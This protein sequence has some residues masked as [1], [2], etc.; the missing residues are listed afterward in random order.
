MLIPAP[1]FCIQF[2]RTRQIYDN[3]IILIL[4]LN[5]IPTDQATQPDISAL[6]SKQGTISDLVGTCH[7]DSYWFIIGTAPP[8][9]VFVCIHVNTHVLPVVT[10]FERVWH[11]PYWVRTGTV[12]LACVI[13]WKTHDFTVNTCRHATFFTESGEFTLIEPVELVNS[14]TEHVKSRVIVCWDTYKVG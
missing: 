6:P 13:T 8:V 2:D 14:L 9:H 4:F 1:C 3:I 7:S 11:E 12:S 10:S 5:F